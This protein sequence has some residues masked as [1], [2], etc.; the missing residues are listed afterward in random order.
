MRRVNNKHPGLVLIGVWVIVVVTG[1]VGAAAAMSFVDLDA[2]AGI[3]AA[4]RAPYIAFVHRDA[5]AVCAS[6][7]QG[8]ANDLAR[9]LPDSGSCVQGVRVAFARTQE[10]GT[11]L[12]LLHAIKIVRV[13]SRGNHAAA[14]IAI[15]SGERAGRF[16]IK[17]ERFHGRWLIST[18]PVL[19]RVTGCH[20]HLG[21]QGCPDG[22]RVLVFFLGVS[23]SHGLPVI[24]PPRAVRLAGRDRLREFKAGALV[25]SESGCLACHRIG[26]QGNVGPGP[27]LDHVGSRL[28]EPEIER[29]ILRAKEPMPSFGGLPKAKFRALVRFLRLLR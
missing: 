5:A 10:L 27:S 23:L 16:V 1:G 20:A 14:T 11:N 4:V 7:T 22:G 28:T 9:E 25:A 24:A 13:G 21:R 18:V 12:T 2:K 15:D 17:L 19:E 3:S 8:A 6:F 26:T 29:A